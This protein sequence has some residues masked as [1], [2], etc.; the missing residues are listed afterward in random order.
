MNG[1]YA[2]PSTLA[3]IRKEFGAV[4]RPANY[5]A[6]PPVFLETVVHEL[7]EHGCAAAPGHADGARGIVEKP[8]G[9]DLASAR[10]PNAILHS[11]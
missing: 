2:D 7:A 5:L 8:F 6:I 3:A 1:D 10:N 4:E 11:V 9:R